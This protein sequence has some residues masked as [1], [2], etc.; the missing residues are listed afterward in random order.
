MSDVHHDRRGTAEAPHAP[1]FVLLYRPGPAWYPDCAGHERSLGEHGRYLRRL[2][3]SRRVVAG[4]PFLGEDGGVVIVRASDRGEAASIAAGDPA[5]QA[6]LLVAEVRGWAPVPKSHPADAG[7]SELAGEML[8]NLDVVRRLFDGVERRDLAAFADAFDETAVVRE[9]PSLPYGGTYHGVDGLGRHAAGYRSAW[10]PV[11]DA[12]ARRLAPEFMPY[13]DRVVVLWRQ[14]GRDASSG[15]R[16]D[17]P[18]VSIYR[19]RDA[20]I[21]ESR[22]FHFDAGAVRAFLDR[23][24]RSLDCRGRQESSLVPPSS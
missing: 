19:L 8:C 6:G 14:R 10:D 13:G 11:Q 4:Q 1:Q 2:E 24:H 7:W 22:M 20:R 3:A 18:A 5:V 23:A 9:A 12:E 16:F 21:V 15:E 17:M